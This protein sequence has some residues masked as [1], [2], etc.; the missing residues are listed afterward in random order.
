MAGVREVYRKLK[1]A[2]EVLNTTAENAIDLTKEIYTRENTEQMLEG[3]NRYG[4]DLSPSY[5]ND[6]YFKSK[7]SAQRY[8]DWKDRITPNP[9]R[10]KGVPNLYIVGTYHK[11]I[12]SRVINGR[13]VVE[14][15]FDAA[16]KIENKYNGLYGLSTPFQID[17]V[18]KMRP[19]FNELFLKSLK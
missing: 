12:T 9:K 7:E 16:N 4:E 18:K 5:L 11:S 2:K 14:S 3:K 6:P 10:K 8:S 1:A 15:T 13:I 17:Y 19:I